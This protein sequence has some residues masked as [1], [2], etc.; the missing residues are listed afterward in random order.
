MAV[1]DQGL[2]PSWDTFSIPCTA[3]HTTFEATFINDGKVI[4]EDPLI[5][6]FRPKRF[7]TDQFFS[8]HRRWNHHGKQRG[9]TFAREQHWSI[10]CA[11]IHGDGLLGDLCPMDGLFNTSW[12][13]IHQ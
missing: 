6:F 10:N 11:R 5:L 12:H 9:H 13:V 3:G 1:V 8:G 4:G 7:F 2:L